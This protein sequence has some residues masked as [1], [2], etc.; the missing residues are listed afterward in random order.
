M[1]N[2]GR[3]I[4]DYR[5]N[6]FIDIAKALNDGADSI[7]LD[8][9]QAAKLLEIHDAIVVAKNELVREL[10]GNKDRDVDVLTKD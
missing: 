2:Q 3:F 4:P 10:Y 6:P 7:T 1:D 5:G 9:S 8:A